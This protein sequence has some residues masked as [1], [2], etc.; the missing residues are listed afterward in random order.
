MDTD[1]IRLSLPRWIE[2]LRRHLLHRLGCKRNAADLAQEAG[3]R[4]LEAL[5][6]GECFVEPRAWMFRVGHNLAVDE[7][8]RRAP[9]PLGLEWQSLIVD[10][11]TEEQEE[12]PVYT[13]GGREYGRSELQP[14]LARALAGLSAGDRALLLRRYVGG[15]RCMDL[16]R[17]DGVSEDAG[18]VRLHRARRRLAARIERVLREPPLHAACALALGACAPRAAGPDEADRKSVV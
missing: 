14:L 10:P 18:K 11:R 4:L 1:H 13:V 2:Q 12:E 6:R 5:A 9:M 3:A 8:R 16:A 7:I 15:R 17:A